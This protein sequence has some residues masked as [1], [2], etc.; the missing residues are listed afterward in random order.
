M[1]IGKVIEL[2]INY[3]FSTLA[4]NKFVN[5]VF[6]ILKLVHLATNLGNKYCNI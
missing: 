6:V 1:V 3:F 2:V 5:Q 4:I